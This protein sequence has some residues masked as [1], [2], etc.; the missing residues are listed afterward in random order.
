MIYKNETSF[1]FYINLK[2]SDKV[3]AEMC[4]IKMHN[5]AFLSKEFY[6]ITERDVSATLDF[7]S[8]T[9]LTPE[10]IG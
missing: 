6:F 10:N 1:N 2:I 9:P 4:K 3:M 7:Y 5:K 8:R